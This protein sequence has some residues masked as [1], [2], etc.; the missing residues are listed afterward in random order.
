[1]PYRNDLAC[2]HERIRRLE[3]ELER[4]KN[5]IPYKERFINILK[6]FVKPLGDDRVLFWGWSILV[7]AFMALPIIMILGH[8]ESN[9]INAQNN[10]SC[11]IAC[12]N[13]GDGIIDEKDSSINSVGRINDKM[14]G[15]EC[16]NNEN[17]FYVIAED[18]Y[19]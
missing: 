14:L 4:F 3:N 5:K 13:F 15:C 8:Y 11:K 17:I 6:I 10:S 16:K 9:M 18:K 1:M 7:F 12:F 2:A 19:K